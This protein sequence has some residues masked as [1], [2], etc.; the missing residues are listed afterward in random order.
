MI[1]SLWLLL[2]GLGAIAFLAGFFALV[3]F[4]VVRKQKR[5]DG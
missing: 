1:S 2:I 3:I 5:G 4:I